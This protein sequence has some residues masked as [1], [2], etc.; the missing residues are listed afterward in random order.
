M[1]EKKNHRWNEFLVVGALTVL[2]VIVVVE[3]VRDGL[4]RRLGLRAPA[5]PWEPEQ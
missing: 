5:E 3:D 2:L 1:S 4:L